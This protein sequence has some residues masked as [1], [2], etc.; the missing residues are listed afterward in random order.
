KNKIAKL[1][2]ENQKI[3]SKL[4]SLSTEESQKQQVKLKKNELEI[5]KLKVKQI[6]QQKALEKAQAQI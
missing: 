3:N 4:S 5:Q 2:S 6:N 1:E